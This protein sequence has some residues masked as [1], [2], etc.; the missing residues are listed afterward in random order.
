MNV[1]RSIVYYAYLG[2]EH[3]PDDLV[4]QRLAFMERQ[5]GW[6]SDLVRGMNERADVLVSYVAPRR[7]DVDLDRTVRNHGFAVD[8]ESV[9]ADRRNTFEYRG[10]TAMK[11]LA[12]VADPNRLIYYCHSKGIVHLEEYKMGIFRLHTHVGLTADLTA[13]IEDPDLT[14]AGLFPYKFGW[15]WYNFFWIKAVRM[16]GLP[17]EEAADRYQFEALI[18]DRGDKEGFRGVLSLLDQVPFEDTGI[19]SQPWYRPDETTT[20]T[21]M[22]AYARYAE[23]TTPSAA[24]SICRNLPQPA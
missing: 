21:L 23:L 12:Q 20:P 10:F 5:L 3:S 17:V 7:W 14:R 24:G 22:R 19:A 16:A 18:G 6:L 13:L 9:R 4:G 8:P 11:A 2:D 15:C 1:V